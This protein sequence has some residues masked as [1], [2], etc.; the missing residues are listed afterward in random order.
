MSAP[1]PCHVNKKIVTNLFFFFVKVLLLELFYWLCTFKSRPKISLQIQH[2]LHA[3]GPIMF[4]AFL[5][6]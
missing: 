3:K 4:F 2:P 6:S 1:E 5:L